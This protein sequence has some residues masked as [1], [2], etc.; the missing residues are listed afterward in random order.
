MKKIIV[1]IFFLTTAIVFSM[2][3][4]TEADPK[5]NPHKITQEELHN[6]AVNYYHYEFEEEHEWK[7]IRV[8]S[9]QSVIK[10]IFPYEEDGIAFFYIVNYNPQG[11]ILIPAYDFIFTP[12]AIS[13]SSGRAKEVKSINDNKIPLPAKRIYLKIKEAVL[14]G[15]QGDIHIN[16]REKKL[17]EN[18]KYTPEKFHEKRNYN[19]NSYKPDW[20]LEKKNLKSSKNTDGLIKTEWHQYN[21]FN[22]NCPKL[23]NGDTTLVGCTP[24]AMAQLMKYYEW[25]VTGIGENSYGWYADTKAPPELLSAN[26]GA[27]TYDWANMLAYD[28]LMV[29]DDQLDAVS[30][31]CK[32]AGIS[33]NADYGI[34]PGTAAWADDIPHNITKY[35]NYT[36]QLL[37]KVAWY[38]NGLVN[39]KDSLIF[40]LQN[41]NPIIYSAYLIPDNDSTKHTWI[42][43]KYDDS[44]QKFHFNLGSTN[45]ESNTWYTSAGSLDTLDKAIFN[46]IPDKTTN[47]LSIPYSENFESVFTSSTIDINQIPKF[48]GIDEDNY[49]TL[50]NVGY[51]NSKALKRVYVPNTN[52]SFLIK[53]I[54][55]DCDS[56]PVL[57]FKYKIDNYQHI[58]EGD[59]LIIEVSKDNRLTWNKISKIDHLNFNS[60]SEYADKI[61]SLNN[62]K[63]DTIN[64]RYH[65]YSASNEN[66]Y[67]YYIDNIEVGELGLHFTDISY[68]DILPPLNAQPIKVT[69]SIVTPPKSKSYEN[70]DMAMDFY[71]KEDIGGAVYTLMYTDSIL[72]NGIF[73]YPNWNT[74]NS[75]GKAFFIKAF[76]RTKSDI[77]TLDSIVTRVEISGRECHID[78]PLP[79][80]ES[81]FDFE[82]RLEILGSIHA[83]EGFADSLDNILYGFDIIDEYASELNGFE[84]SIFL[85]GYY[86]Y[87]GCDSTAYF[88]EF[89][90]KDKK[91]LEYRPERIKILDNNTSSTIKYINPDRSKDIYSDF[92]WRYPRSLDLYP[93]TYTVYMQAIR[94][95]LYQSYGI[96]SEIAKT[97]TIQFII[98]QWKLKLRKDPWFTETVPYGMKRTY[99]ISKPMEMQVWRPFG[100]PAYNSLY[101]DILR[102]SD[103]TVVEN[104]TIDFNSK[105]V[106]ETAEW[107]PDWS[108]EPGFYM[109]KSN[110]LDYYVNMS[111]NQDIL[112]QV[113]PLYLSWEQDGVWPDNWPGGEDTANWEMYNNAW[114][115]AIGSYSLGAKYNTNSPGKET[116]QRQS[117]AISGQWDRVLEFAI[118]LPKSAG[119]S[120]FDELLA[121]YSIATSKDGVNW[122]IE[123][124]PKIEEYNIHSWGYDPTHSFIKT[125]KPLG[126]VSNFGLKFITNGS[127]TTPASTEQT[128][129]FDEIKVD[130]TKEASKPAP[131]NYQNFYTDGNV[132]VNWTAP[133]VAK[134]TKSFDTYYVYRNGFKI[135]ETT[136]LTFTDTSIETG[137]FYSYSVTSHYTDIT[138]YNES[139]ML[140]CSG[141][142]YTDLESPS[143]LVIIN[144]DPNI[145]LTWNTVD[146]ATNYKVYS[147]DDPYGTFTE[148]TNGSFNVTEW[149]APLSESKLFYYVVA[150]NTKSSL[151]KST[152][153]L[154][155]NR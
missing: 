61:I 96:V 103:N 73:E 92:Y 126:D 13:G 93:G 127:A 62:F 35:F 16:E 154:N 116:L 37:S 144:E 114:S 6:I 105:A 78:F 32:H 59:S 26:F 43:D 120:N 4:S 1:L 34:Y 148:D 122:T 141:S 47:A 58:V 142:I 82:T 41:D 24:L 64:I 52:D 101:I 102:E 15:L 14:K 88:C 11:N 77:T 106:Y 2:S 23:S 51:N 132:I 137:K 30:T 69:P 3:D 79:A 111:V 95:D 80:T 75:L 53:K 117:L 139:P 7:E 66:S 118:G 49:R 48:I 147:S 152:D 89:E 12:G 98:P 125:Y 19:S 100:Q 109:I 155:L 56:L 9:S 70:C 107:I 129:L 140:D 138:M 39:W 21:P 38:P 110:E 91:Q 84:V 45:Y 8:D 83:E 65:F 18:L 74:N 29:T 145:K 86:D 151:L 42:I 136:N 90:K 113:C 36:S 119:V 121:D 40:A 76:A 33:L 50:G 115:S 133:P 94:K 28:S 135:G 67:E 20:W 17:W 55:L 68:D 124:T 71:L 108:T 46:V 99:Q 97:D 5:I 150:T 31:L 134:D 22:S 10:N 104:F 87:Y 130:F 25:P 153:R 57:R 143:N 63:N 146:G 44:V 81:W 123:K 72:E 149:V 54:N 27:T 60:T 112:T 128:V 131:S 85:Q